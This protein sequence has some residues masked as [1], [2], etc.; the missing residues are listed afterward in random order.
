MAIDSVDSLPIEA[1]N[2]YCKVCMSHCGLVAEVQ[3]DRILKVRGDK[4][5]PLTQGYTCPKGRATGEFHHQPDPI[6]R[7]LMKKDGELV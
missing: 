3:G 2:T 4:E 6:T 7:P 5:H 1:K